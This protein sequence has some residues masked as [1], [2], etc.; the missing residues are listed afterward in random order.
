MFA[1]WTTRLFLV[2]SAELVSLPVTREQLKECRDALKAVE[3]LL[4][5]YEP[6]NSKI[7][8]KSLKALIWA[9]KNGKRDSVLKRLERQKTILQLALLGTSMYL[10]IGA[11][12]NV[13]I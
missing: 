6:S 3:M 9:L 10:Y 2:Y 13:G 4:R 8:G 12:T 7:V 1:A 5:E 11:C